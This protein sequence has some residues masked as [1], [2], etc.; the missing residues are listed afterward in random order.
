MLDIPA[1]YESIIGIGVISLLNAPY[2]YHNKIID[3][4]NI[5]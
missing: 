2:L 3:W 4:Y 5:F 1:D